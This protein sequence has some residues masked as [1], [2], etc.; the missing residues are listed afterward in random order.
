MRQTGLLKTAWLRWFVIAL[1]L[2]CVAG[3]LI[4]PQVDLPAFVVR[5]GQTSVASHDLTPTDF[6]L[7][8]KS[9]AALTGLFGNLPFGFNA[10]GRFEPFEVPGTHSVLAQLCTHRC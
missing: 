8:F 9:F 6:V 1:V 5:P 4:L 3:V 2:V 10:L 7:V